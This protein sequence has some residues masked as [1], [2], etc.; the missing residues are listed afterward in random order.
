MPFWRRRLDRHSMRLL[1]SERLSLPDQL[2]EIAAEACQLRFRPA[3]DA[4]VDRLKFSGDEMRRLARFE[5][6]RYAAHALVMP[7]GAFQTAALRARYDLDVL[8]S[9]FGVSF[10]QVANRL[11]MLARSGHAGIPFFMMEVDQAGNRFRRAGAQGFPRARFGGRCPKLPLHSAFASP[12]QVLVERSIM[13]DGAEFLLIARTLET[14]IAIFGERLRQTA[15]LL[16][17]DAGFAGDTVYGDATARQAG[18]VEIGPACRLC[19]RGSCLARAE[20]AITRP[21]GLDAMVSG[22]NAFDHQ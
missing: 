11:T 13:P 19:E 6:C 8:R 14:P 12:G 3:I 18:P 20:P 2:R 22:V 5:L 16:G 21:L 4:E 10:E 17:C 7:Y 1:I 15:L 9:R